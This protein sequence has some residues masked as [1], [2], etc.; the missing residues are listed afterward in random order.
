MIK[1]AMIRLDTKLRDHK[2]RAAMILQIHDELLF[3]APREE[4]QALCE[5]VTAEM[6][7]ALDLIVPVKVNIAVGDN[8]MNAK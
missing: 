8:W 7:G 2:M 3:D 5:I 4:E 1:I 6:T